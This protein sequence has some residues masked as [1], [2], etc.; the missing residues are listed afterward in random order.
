MPGNHERYL[1][2]YFIQRQKTQHQ[3]DSVWLQFTDDLTNLKRKVYFS[4][5][6]QVLPCGAEGTGEQSSPSR[7]GQAAESRM[8]PFITGLFTLS[9]PHPMA[10]R[11]SQCE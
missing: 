4:S 11:C 9:G 8:T 5:E 6:S 2:S 7:D 10:W 1:S 3:L